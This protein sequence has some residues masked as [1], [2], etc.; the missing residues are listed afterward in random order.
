MGARVVQAQLERA[1]G[2]ADKLLELVD[3]KNS[4]TLGSAD[5]QAFINEVLDEGNGDVNGYIGMVV[6]LASPVLQ[7]AP[8][9]IRY[10][11][12]IDAYLVWMKSTGGL[13]M[14]PEIRSEYERVTGELEKIGSRKKGIGLLIRPAS[15]Q[16]IQQ[17]EDDPQRDYFSPVGPRRRYDG[18]S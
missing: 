11:L 7:T 4:G 1:V 10:E 6:D 3:K 5:C 14:P 9:L 8:T 17:V 18:W 13:G 15:G 16:P 2:G 12:A